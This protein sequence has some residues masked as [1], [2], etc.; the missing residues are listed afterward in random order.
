MLEEHDYYIILY[1]YYGTLL[2]DKQQKYFEDY[3]FYNLSLSEIS[4]NYNIS[5]NAIHK[6]IKE[7]K[8]LLD[9]YEEKLKLL[10][11]SKNITE[12][13]KDLDVELQLKIKEW[14]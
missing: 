5:R 3:Y 13:I 1:D 7:T 4:D 8:E 10:E 14:I 6:S 12:L 2:T 11:K 9:Y